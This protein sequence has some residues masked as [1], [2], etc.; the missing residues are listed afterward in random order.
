MFM[1]NQPSGNQ[2][3]QLIQESLRNG[4]QA[5]LAVTSNSMAPLIRRGDD[6]LIVSVER[7][8]PGDIITFTTETGLLTHRFWGILQKEEG[9][10]MLTRG[11]KP[12]FFDPLTPATN[13]LGLIVGRQR[14][15][16]WLNLQEGRGQWL[17]HHL[18]RL[19]ALDNRILLGRDSFPLRAEPIG[20]TKPTW[21]Q[22]AMH[23]ALYSWARVVTA[24]VNQISASNPPQIP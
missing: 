12:L 13:L 14:H 8:S 21:W 7:P 11:D 22:Q 24:V 2:L 1:H 5:T 10:F 9:A 19:A 16:R 20:S 17:N 15:G 23:W 6:V 18:K 3:A 4:R